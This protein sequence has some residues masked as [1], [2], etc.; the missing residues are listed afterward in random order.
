MDAGKASILQFSTCSFKKTQKDTAVEKLPSM[1][2][3]LC[4][5]LSTT[6]KYSLTTKKIYMCQKKKKKNQK[7]DSVT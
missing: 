1:C 7:D 5:I 2:K 6:Y 3:V 4:S